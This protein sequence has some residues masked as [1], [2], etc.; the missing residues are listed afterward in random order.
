[1]QTCAPDV[2]ITEI[3]RGETYGLGLFERVF[4]STLIILFIVG[5]ASLI[6]QPIPGLALGLLVWGFMAYS[7]FVP[8]WSIILTLIVGVFFLMW[9][10]GG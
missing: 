8:L 7:G 6:G 2:L 1:M 5:I 9:K 3:D 10:S 4:I